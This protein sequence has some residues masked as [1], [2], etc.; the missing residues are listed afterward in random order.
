MQ[1]APH[2]ENETLRIAALHA[3]GVLDTEPEPAFDAL[4]RVASLICGVP[5]SLIS[6]VDTE[7]QWFKANEGLHE[8]SETA[9]DIA[10]CSHAILE[11]DVFEVA[12]AL[13]DLRFV[14][15]PLVTGNPG[16]RF[17]AG[18]PLVLSDGSRVGTLCV[19]DRVPRQMNDMQ[20]EVLR[21]LARAA[22]QALEG[23][24]GIREA[25]RISSELRDSEAWFRALS[26][27]SPHGVF[28]ADLQGACTYTNSRWQDIY[29]LTSEQ[30][31][32]RGWMRG[33]RAGDKA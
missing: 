27:G 29:G 9:R 24:H 6:L 3:L 12:D 22:V 30:S 2:P 16:I 13:K 31:L 11:D 23:R 28:Y 7:R 21:C 19:I 17:Y 32:G 20:R 26:D 5:I 4:V 25:N 1:P 10:F 15:N 8:A 33:M 14:D 18:A